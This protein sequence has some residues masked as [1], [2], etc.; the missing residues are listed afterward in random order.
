LPSPTLFMRTETARAL[1]AYDKGVYPDDYNF[2]LKCFKAGLKFG[3]TDKIILRWRDHPQRLSRTA[4]E[5]QDQR[6]F[7]LKARYFNEMKINHGRPVIVWG[8]G[9]NGKNL[10]KAFQKAGLAIAGFTASPE[11]IKEKSLYGLPVRQFQEYSGVFYVLAT[12]AKGAREEAM[13][14]LKASGLEETRD[15]VAVC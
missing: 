5:L 11:H 13:G 2:T 3:K 14:K 15:F 6:F 4:P 10:C 7:D 9:R 12:A 1:G 8:I